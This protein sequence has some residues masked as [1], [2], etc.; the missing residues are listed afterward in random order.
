LGE[1]VTGGGYPKN[2][3]LGLG[4]RWVLCLEKTEKKKPKRDGKKKKG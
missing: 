1:L 2:K 4:T 3:N